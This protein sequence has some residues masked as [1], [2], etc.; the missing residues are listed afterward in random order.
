M[1]YYGLSPKAEQSSRISRQTQH[2]GI[3]QASNESRAESLK[4]Y[5]QLEEKCPRSCIWG[6][7]LNYLFR[8][9]GKYERFAN[10]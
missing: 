6:E 10:R 1:S 2:P 8:T 9:N 4:Y 3:I 5:T 7:A